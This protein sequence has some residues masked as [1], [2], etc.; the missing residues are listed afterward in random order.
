[1][2]MDI[3]LVNIGIHARTY[4]LPDSST[5]GLQLVALTSQASPYGPPPGYHHYPGQTCR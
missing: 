4:N 3:I 2:H 5:R 1:M